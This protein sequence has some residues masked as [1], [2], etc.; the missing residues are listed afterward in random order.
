M[1]D[2]IM[3]FFFERVMPVLMSVFIV[4]L[5]LLIVFSPFLIYSCVSE[6]SRIKSALHSS[7]Y[8]VAD[9]NVFLNGIGSNWFEFESSASLRKQY[10]KFTLG[11]TSEWTEDAK[12]EKAKQDAHSSGFVT[13]AAVGVSINAGR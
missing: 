5:C 13:G 11:E 3:E 2:M 9:V 6:E 10:D 7:G 4:G 12:A 1:I 8:D